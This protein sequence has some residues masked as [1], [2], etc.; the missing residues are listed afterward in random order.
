MPEVT[1]LT[2]AALA[3]TAMV[4]FATPAP[5]Q[6]HTHG[7]MT[8]TITHD[9]VIVWTRASQAA[10]VSVLYATNPSLNGARAPRHTCYFES[11]EG[12]AMKRSLCI[13]LALMAIAALILAG[14]PG[15]GSMKRSG[16]GG[17]GYSGYS[18]Y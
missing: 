11:N 10:V 7:D 3:S 14:C 9:S 12:V 6:A 8:G 5:A 17:G 1:R 13:G 16:S 18:R 4:W 2:I 15:K